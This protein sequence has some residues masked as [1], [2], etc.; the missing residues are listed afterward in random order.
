MA[1]LGSGR[2]GANCRQKLLITSEVTPARA[3]RMITCAWPNR[4]FFGAGAQGDIDVNTVP[5]LG[6]ATAIAATD[7]TKAAAANGRSSIILGAL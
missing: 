3:R 7:H 6:K 5:D 4:A 1:L 2:F